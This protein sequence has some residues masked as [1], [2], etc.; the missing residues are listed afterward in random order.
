VN[1]VILASG[2]IAHTGNVVGIGQLT[3]TLSQ[4]KPAETLRLR[5]D[6]R[7]GFEGEIK[8]PVPQ[9]MYTPAC[10]F[11]IW[12]EYKEQPKRPWWHRIKMRLITWK[13]RLLILWRRYRTKEE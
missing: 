8:D 9:V 3:F 5:G 6:E 12:A 4:P 11:S 7:V 10:Q 13:L 2:D 1:I